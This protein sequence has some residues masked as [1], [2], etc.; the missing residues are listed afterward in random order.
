MAFSVRVAEARDYEQV[1]RLTDV[2]LNGNARHAY[3]RNIFSNGCLNAVCAREEDGLVVGFITVLLP[4]A[5]SASPEIWN[6]LRPYVGFVG[7][8]PEFRRKGLCRDLLGSAVVTIRRHFPEEE[9]LS[10]Q[11]REHLEDFYLN[12]GF[13]K[14]PDK[15]VMTRYGTEPTIPVF[16]FRLRKEKAISVVAF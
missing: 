10:L 6:R 11:C 15:E 1:S 9:C 8:I 12:L 3:E 14:V 13:R 4:P 16:Q 7:V 2:C 5:A